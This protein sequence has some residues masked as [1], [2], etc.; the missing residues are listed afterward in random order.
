MCF[1]EGVGR[2]ILSRRMVSLA[3]AGALAAPSAAQVVGGEWETLHRFDGEAPGDFLG[4]AVDGAGDLDGDGFGD[5]IVAANHADPNGIFDAGSVFVY[6]GS[7]GDVLWRFDGDEAAAQFG[8]AVSGWEDIDGDGVPEVIVGAL[9][10]DSGG[11]MDAGS[12]FV[13]SGATGSVIWRFDG[14]SVGETFG[15]S[16]AGAGDMS[17]DGIADL[18]VGSKRADPNGITNAGSVFVYSG[19][20]GDVLHRFDGTGVEDQFGVRV[21]DAGDLDGDGFPD[22]LVG[23]WLSDPN[24]LG[25]AGSVHAYSGRSGAALWTAEGSEVGGSLGVAVSGLGDV[26]EDGIPDVVAGAR[27]TDPG[28]LVDAGSVFV[29]SGS[30]GG[31]LARVDGEGPGDWLGEFLAGA[32]D[33]DGDAFPD[34]IVGARKASPGGLTEAGSA[35]LCSGADGS[36]LR[37]FDGPAAGDRFGQ[38]VS[39]AGDVDGDGAP[40]LVIGAYLSDPGGL[41]DAGSAY[42]FRLDPFLVTEA[43]TISASGGA[44]AL[45]IEFPPSEAGVGFAVLASAA[46]TG[47]AQVGALEIPLT[48]DAIFDRMLLGWVPPVLFGSPGTL[49]AQARASSTVVGGPALAPFVGETFH[50][51][52]VSFD[53]GT[54][55]GRLSSI[56]RPLAVVP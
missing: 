3:L 52:V 26:D 45:D 28:G 39:G 33:V 54:L 41:R 49:D 25:D 5:L 29:L 10:R 50:L 37:R 30:N 17:G 27:G 44:V 14:S 8:Q 48:Q 6:S 12:V 35:Y 15:F 56:A 34:F 9:R 22:V 21:A 55:N 51:A 24:G 53:P 40:D 11:L 38:A 32:G 18:I 2:W 43:S 36:V 1:V 7:T 4:E 46:G 42:V 20:T 31:V 19:A 16:V 23:A 13:F 47:P